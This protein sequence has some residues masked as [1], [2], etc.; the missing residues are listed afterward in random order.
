MAWLVYLLIV[1]LVL[2]ITLFMIL[3]T[4]KC[5]S[6][7]MQTEQTRGFC[8]MKQRNRTNQC[9]SANETSHHTSSSSSSSSDTYSAASLSCSN[10]F[11]TDDLNIEVTNPRQ[12]DTNA[13]ENF[14]FIS[15]YE[16]TSRNLSSS[17]VLINRKYD[18][19]SRF[20]NAN[21]INTISSCIDRENRG[22]C[23]SNSF[24][25]YQNHDSLNLNCNRVDTA[26][27]GQSF[28]IELNERIRKKTK[29]TEEAA[30]TIS[31][32]SSEEIL[33][34]EIPPNYNEV[35]SE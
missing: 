22:E 8:C 26:D 17:A 7:C 35:Y 23:S 27:D 18:D 20:F 19:P 14:G 6:T 5:L 29:R 34:D 24:F 11:E 25:S 16:A 9:A 15:D 1:L 33:S 21:N 2:I 31:I 32:C 28:C 10:E 4:V 30:S 13:C 12:S 3:F